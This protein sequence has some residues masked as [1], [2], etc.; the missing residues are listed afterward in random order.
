MLVLRRKIGEEIRIG[1]DVV[2]KVLGVN[3]RAIRLGIQ[4]PVS[5]PIRRG[6][7]TP[8]G[9]VRQDAPHEHLLTAK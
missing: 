9:T 4:A 2:I 3:G 1:D 6:E 5:M 8:A 7:W